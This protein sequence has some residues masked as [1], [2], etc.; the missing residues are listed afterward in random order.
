MNT[1]N[2]TYFMSASSA[3]NNYEACSELCNYYH[4][5]YSPRQNNMPATSL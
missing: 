2:L 5:V 3:W 4:I 1:R